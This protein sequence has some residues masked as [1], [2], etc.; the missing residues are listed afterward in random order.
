MIDINISFNVFASFMS[1]NQYAA[2]AIFLI[3]GGIIIYLLAFISIILKS[4]P[5]MALLTIFA[6]LFSIVI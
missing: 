3:V 1:D 6:A 5:M 4:A 2:P